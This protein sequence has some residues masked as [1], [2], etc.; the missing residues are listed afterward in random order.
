MKKNASK[1]A[2]LLIIA[3]MTAILISALGVMTSAARDEEIT[4]Y[5]DVEYPLPEITE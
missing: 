1:I 3:V 2:R 5:V 4:R